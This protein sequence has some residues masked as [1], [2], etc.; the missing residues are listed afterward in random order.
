MGR[1]TAWLAPVAVTTNLPLSIFCEGV[2]TAPDTTSRKLTLGRD[3]VGWDDWVVTGRAF[4]SGVEAGDVLG[5]SAT[6][7]LAGDEVAG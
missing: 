4:G 5:F 3:G 7:D 2:L 1:R 6:D